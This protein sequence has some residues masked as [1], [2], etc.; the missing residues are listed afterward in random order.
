MQ[1]HANELLAMKDDFIVSKVMSYL[2]NCIK[3]FENAAVV[4]KEIKRF[5]KSLTHFFPG[6]LFN[7]LLATNSIT[8]IYE[9][10]ES[11]SDLFA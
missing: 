11:Q 1:Y 8:I 6:T 4:N 2:S 5:P 3:D 7:N 9:W 10:V